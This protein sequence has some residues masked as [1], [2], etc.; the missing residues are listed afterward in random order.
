MENLDDSRI[1]HIY[2]DGEIETNSND[3][4][5]VFYAKTPIKDRLDFKSSLHEQVADLYPASTL[6]CH[7]VD[8]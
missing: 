5:G 1:R 2:T 8:E 4:L 6:L 7:L 3:D